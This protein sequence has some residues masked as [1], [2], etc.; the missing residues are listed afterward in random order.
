MQQQQ[1]KKYTIIVVDDGS[2][3]GT[4]TYLKENFK[5]VIVLE[6]DGNLWWTGATN[7]GVKKA[8]ELSCSD[9]DFILTL[10][11]DLE[12]KDDY[13]EQLLAAASS[14][15]ASLIG[16]LSVDIAKPDK[17]HFAGTK[18]NSATAKYGP[19]LA[20]KYTCT[21]LEKTFTTVKTDLL[22][23]RGILIPIT[24]FHKIGL[25]DFNA[26]PHYMADEDFSL[27]AKKNY[28]NLL[29]ATRAVVYNHVAETGIKTKHKNWRYLKDTFTSIK[30]PVNF[31]NRWNWA[32]KH[33]SFP[34]AYFI[35]DMARI[36][37]GMIFK[38]LPV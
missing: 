25:Y 20:K 22:P 33:A 9:N 35:F 12:V 10:N 29:I 31:N 4:S 37:K 17:V 16:S 30:S 34:A 11:N 13:L 24:V 19:A 1:Y 14:N 38:K 6:G 36:M 26:F 28:F 21:E 2:A 15:P 32:K 7:L 5:Q 23:G 18:W 8:L 3:D 27:R